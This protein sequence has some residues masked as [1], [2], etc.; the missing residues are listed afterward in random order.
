MEDGQLCV[1]TK[2]E[3]NED[4]DFARN[5]QV[6]L[7]SAVGEWSS[8]VF[9]SAMDFNG[10]TY[11]GPN[12]D[13]SHQGLLVSRGAEVYKTIDTLLFGGAGKVG[14]TVRISPTYIQ[15]RYSGLD[16]NFRLINEGLSVEFDREGAKVAPLIDLREM[17]GDSTPQTHSASVDGEW[18]FVTNGDLRLK[19]GPIDHADLNPASTD[20]VYKHGS[21]Y[22]FRDDKGYVRFI[23]EAR[24]V[25]SPGILTVK[26]SELQVSMQG[27]ESRPLSPVEG[28][29]WLSRV[30]MLEPGISKPMLLRLLTL[31]NF[32]ID[33]GGVWFPEA[34]CW[35]FRRPWVRD[36]L[37]G[38]LSNFKVYTQL[39]GWKARVSDLALMLLKVMKAKGGLP[40][41]IGRDEHSAD[42][43]PLLL[44]LCSLL[45]HEPLK[46]G[47]DATV[48]L[49]DEMDS[50][51]SSKPGPPVLLGGLVACAPN[52]TWTDSLLGEEGRPSRLPASWELKRQ[53][54]LSPGFYLPEINGYWIRALRSLIKRAN[55]ERLTV[56][57]RI[58]ATLS[59]MESGFR[60]TIWDG[61]Y[62]ANIIEAKSMRRDSEITSMGMVGISSTL[63][64]FDGAEAKT[65]YASAKRLIINRRLTTIGTGSYPF[66]IMI[67]R[68]STPY[69]GDSEYHRS[70]IWPRET[71]YLIR[72]MDSIGLKD[73]VKGVLMNTLDQSVSESVLLY[74]N[75][76]FGL[77]SGKNP[78]SSSDNRNVIPLKNPA[79]F[80]SHWC[81]PFLERFFSIH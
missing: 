9:S 42:A 79:Q 68:Q 81:D 22:R 74:S 20:W 6:L 30:S 48:R 70:V 58:S 59:A 76:I 28:G 71:P 60:R 45:G 46:L 13:F 8:S 39:F 49:L 51:E 41:I 34:G 29:G 52:Q 25:F 23:R 5:K 16:A 80:W 4:W 54:W 7:K 62:A 47:I 77:P 17:N 72:L 24:R 66:G 19:I 36:A 35:W 43:P 73:E 63:H 31:S 61:T 27:G 21:G 18:A 67:S 44:Y 12:R 69:T 32:G 65:A 75:E 56:P 57:D 15:Y 37:E 2:A 38:V 26:G 11:V 64:I 3:E 33:G 50:R 78:D 53:E 14:L 1:E 55:E 40:T 10:E